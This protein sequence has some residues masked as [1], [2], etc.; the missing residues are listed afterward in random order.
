MTALWEQDWV[1]YAKPPFG[2]PAQVL[3]YL[4]RYTH[5]VAISNQRLVSIGHGVVR[6]EYHDYADPNTRKQLPLPATEFLRRFLLHVVPKGFMRIRHYGITA[7]ARR[8]KKLARCRE[9]TPDSPMLPIL[10][11]ARYIEPPRPLHTPVFF[12]IN[13]NTSGSRAAPLAIGCPCEREVPT[14]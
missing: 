5:R 7:N 3:K 8:Q 11:S 6:F 4:S 13:S 12:P 9:T 1:V 14:I 10:K 2:G